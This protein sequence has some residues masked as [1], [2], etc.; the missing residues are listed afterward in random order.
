MSDVTHK[1]VAASKSIRHSNQM[2]MWKRQSSP[3]APPRWGGRQ[4]E[5]ER[6]AG[7][8]NLGCLIIWQCLVLDVLQSLV[9]VILSKGPRFSS[10][11]PFF[12]WTIWPLSQSLRASWLP[13]A[14]VTRVAGFQSSSVIASAPS[15]R[16]LNYFSFPLI[17]FTQIHSSC[18]RALALS[19]LSPPLLSHL[20]VHV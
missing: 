14:D 12:T 18:A 13:E 10:L 8:C 3:L 20:F 9:R 16:T 1:P 5:P 11:I 15:P 19:R 4:S 6:T 2:F 17:I 7:C